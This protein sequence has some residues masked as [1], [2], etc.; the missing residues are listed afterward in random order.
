MGD[1]IRYDQ[2]RWDKWKCLALD[3]VTSPHSRRAYETALDHF[4]AWYYAEPRPPFSKAVVNAYKVELETAGFSASAIN[5]RLCALRKL[6]SEAA[7]NGLIATELAASIAKV[8]GVPQHGVRIGNWLTRQQAERLMDAPDAS[9]ITGKRDQALLA[10]LIGCGL[11]R[12]EAAALTFNHLQQREGRCVIVDL[13]GKHGRIR[14]IPIPA[15]AEVAVDQWSV[16]SGIYSGCIFR[17][18]NRGGKLTH[19]SLTGK[20]IWLI[21]RKYTAELGWPKLAPH[22]LRRTFAKLAYQGGAK[23]EQIQMSLGHAS[24]Q[25]TERYLGVKQDLTDAPCDHL[26]LKLYPAPTEDERAA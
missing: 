19:E 2:G 23:L 12:S 18:I 10:V 14:S 4:D 21:L 3:S 5:L 22:D 15:F 25:T 6:V 11:R 20:C 9:T 8:R 24:I 1:L 26:G 16:A 13:V 17:P 7:D